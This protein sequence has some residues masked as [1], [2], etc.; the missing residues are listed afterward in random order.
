MRPLYK[1][2]FI[3]QFAGTKNGLALLELLTR[4]GVA[5]LTLELLTFSVLLVIN[6]LLSCLRLLKLS[7][8]KLMAFQ[9]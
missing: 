1:T 8:N 9:N 6:I 2:K 4:N 7:G 3:F 5:L